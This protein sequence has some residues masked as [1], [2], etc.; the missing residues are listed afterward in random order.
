MIIFCSHRINL[1]GRSFLVNEYSLINKTKQT[2]KIN[3]MQI[4]ILCCVIPRLYLMNHFI[5]ICLTRK[6]CYD[7]ETNFDG[8]GI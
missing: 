4:F 7:K 1:Y 2:N 5:N 6:G 3:S 8:N